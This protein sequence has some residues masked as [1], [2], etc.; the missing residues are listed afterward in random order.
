MSTDTR[1]DETTISDRE[2]R[3][4]PSLK[5]FLTAFALL[6]GVSSAWA[7]ASPL[8]SVPDEP[9]H[10]VHAAAVVRGELDGAPS[11]VQP[12]ALDVEVPAFVADTADLACFA[13]DPSR[14][15]SCQAPLTDSTAPETATTSAGTYNPAYYAV[16]GLPSLFLEGEPALYAM[17]VL[18]AALSSALLALAVVAVMQMRARAWTLVAFSVAVTPMVYFIMGSVNPSGIEIASAVML[19]AWLSLLVQRR[20]EGFPAHRIAFVAVAA[21][22]LANTRSI[23]LLW[24]LLIVV[25]TL[26]D[27]SLIRALARRRAF[28]L[29]VVGIGVG[30][31]AGLAWTLTSQSLSPGVPYVGAGSSFY[32]G[33]NKMIFIT[34]E[35]GQGYIGLFGWIDTPAPATTVII[36]SFVL[37]SLIIGALAFGR[38][39]RRR[40][41][42]ILALAMV[43]VPPVVQGFAVTDY[44]YIWQ[45]RYILAVLACLVLAAGMALDEAFPRPVRLESS[46]R[47]VTSGL[48][49]LGV[50][51]VHLVVWV[52][53]RYVTGL[54]DG[55]GWRA[56]FTSPSWQPPLT[57]EFWTAVIAVLLA[58]GSI[59]VRRA[60]T[61]SWAEALPEGA[62]APSRPVDAG[63][64]G[65]STT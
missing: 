61:A 5:V 62:D 22:V 25:S 60:V 30:A 31:A 13:F 44:G 3:A 6:W 19:F 53:R 12:G 27:W 43:V 15:A 50:L 52:F 35:N 39:A 38:G 29:G 11:T 20:S 18:S 1:S 55:V 58:A 65:R 17:R 49:A 36:W 24:L 9:A 59:V 2:R 16:V 48:V 45:A 37:L 32:S 7:F 34:F 63:R 23:A 40:A 56:M 28:W 64:P 51:H 8:M 10:T 21:V 26:A 54:Q 41:V 4:R 47:L 14:P 46:R 42:T 57:W 33:F